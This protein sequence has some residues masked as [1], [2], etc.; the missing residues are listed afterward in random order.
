MKC[1]QWSQLMSLRKV[2][3]D[4]VRRKRVFSLGILRYTMVLPHILAL[5]VGTFDRV[6]FSIS[7]PFF[8]LLLYAVVVGAFHV[9]H[10]PFV[11]HAGALNQLFFLCIASSI[12]RFLL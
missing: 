5:S 9:R 6:F 8:P 12:A 2:Q 3:K 4:F 1:P 7:Q 10:F 11:H